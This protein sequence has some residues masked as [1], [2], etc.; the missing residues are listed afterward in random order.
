MRKLFPPSSP[1]EHDSRST[2]LGISL[3]GIGVT[4]HSS[5]NC[6]TLHILGLPGQYQPAPVSPFY[7][8]PLA[9]VVR[10][11]I[12]L[13]KHVVAIDSAVSHP[14]CVGLGPPYPFQPLSLLDRPTMILAFSRS[15]PI[16]YTSTQVT[17]RGLA[18]RLASAFMRGITPLD[19][20]HFEYFQ[21]VNAYSLMNKILTSTSLDRN[22][23]TA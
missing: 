20:R 2:C 3:P 15:L 13:C 14:V 11:S 10:P 1:L 7:L 9:F 21:G 5:L 4:S 17:E 12:L 19:V 8:T 23:I 16:S 22:F 18:M 6:S